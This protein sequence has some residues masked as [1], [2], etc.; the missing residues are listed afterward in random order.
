[1]FILVMNTITKGSSHTFCGRRLVPGG[2]HVPALDRNQSLLEIH[3]LFITCL[4]VLLLLPDKGGDPRKALT[5]RFFFSSPF[6]AG[7]VLLSILYTPP[8]TYARSSYL[9]AY[10]A[11]LLSH[12][13]AHLLL[14][15]FISKSRLVRHVASISVGR[16]MHEVSYWCLMG[17]SL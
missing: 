11:L 5:V 6:C 7:R 14:A 17:A 13:L 8:S 9:S 15:Y 12:L 1:V 16:V 2:L 3:F 4:S 10:S